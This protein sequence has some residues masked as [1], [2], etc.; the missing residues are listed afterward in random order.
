V[1]RPVPAYDI[2]SAPDGN[3][4]ERFTVLAPGIDVDVMPTSFGQARLWF[5]DRLSPDSV[6]YVS[7]FPLRVRGPF[8]EAAFEH[9][10]GVVV[11]RHEALRTRFAAVEGEPVQVIVPE[12]RIPV[13]RMDLSGNDDPLTSAR[14][15]ARQVA[16]TRF[17]LARGPLVRVVAAR[18]GADDWALLL[19]LHHIVVD[20]WS[21]GLLLAELAEAYSARLASRP[22]R[23]PPLTLQYGDY[24]VW[25]R[26]HFRGARLAE[27]LGYWRDQLR[28]PPPLMLPSDRLRPSRQ[29][30]RG[31]REAITVEASAVTALRALAQTE[32]ASLFMCLLAAY[33]VL[34]Q[35][36]SGQADLLIGTPVAGRTRANLEPLIGFFV[37]MLVLRLD[38]SGQP[39]FRELLRRTRSVALDA[40]SQQD[41]PFER[42]V[43]ELTPERR[44]SHN[45]LF[46]TTFAL[47][48][49]AKADLWPGLQV[50]QLAVPHDSVK[51]DLA[52]TCA[53]AGYQLAARFTY[54]TDLFDASTIRRLAAHYGTVLR[55]V[56]RQPDRP[57][58]QLRLLTAAERAVMDGCNDTGSPVP[59]GCVHE[60][61]ATN[62]RRTPDAPAIECEGS[63]VSYLDLDRRSERLAQML[64]ALG[65]EPDRPVALL[66]A[67]GVD[68]VSAQLGVLKA[69]AAFLPLDVTTPRR[70]IAALLAAAK[71]LAVLTTSEHAN[72][73]PHDAPA[74][75]LLDHG[76]PP[77]SGPARPARA[78]TPD[79]LAYLIATSGTTGAPKLV[80]IE[81]RSVV[82]YLT[83]FNTTVLGDGGIRML[84]LSSPAFDA[85]VKQLIGPL[86]RG[87]PVWLPS[88]QERLDP[89]RLLA[90]L[91]ARPQVAL[92]CVPAMWE[93]LLDHLDATGARP[94]DSLELVL[95]GGERLT[96]QLATRTFATF[97][98]ATLWN[99]YGPTEATVNVLGGV[100]QPGEVVTIGRPIANATA[101]V[102]GPGGT[103]QPI[104]V[105]GELYVGGLGLARGYRDDPTQTKA[106]FGPHPHSPGRRLYRTGDRVVRVPDGR[107][108]FIGRDDAQVKVR[109]VRI[110]LDEIA[111]SLREHPAVRDAVVVPHADG[112]AAYLV[113]NGEPAPAHELR[114]HL[115]A[116]LPRAALPATFTLLDRLPLTAVGKL[117]R[118]ALPAPRTRMTAS[119]IPEART[120]T[121]ERVAAIWRAL[122]EQDDFGRDDNFFDVGGHSLLLIRVHSRL[123]PATPALSVLDLFQYPT[124]RTLA[125]RIDVL[126][127]GS[128]QRAEDQP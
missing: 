72:L 87:G 61:F 114:E 22:P 43:S 126:R 20:A 5:L 78:V 42:L 56:G 40:Y 50:S 95:L 77:G 31:G 97:P 76:L 25:Q 44:L 28:H 71:P 113:G 14:T 21:A 75:L 127:A 122:L 67:H 83:W 15:L 58:G 116:W 35:R 120:A 69:G 121:E 117:D 86:L 48:T 54:A 79:N 55:E 30:H 23:L 96:D 37:N 73:L 98:S 81:H 18:L 24:A 64:T 60:L 80:E 90:A 66:L 102:L 109:G 41:I 33:G 27:Q 59:D 19:A 100:V 68:L 38:L 7:D 88:P 49:G 105:P 12:L 119:A 4:P 104:G 115:V 128:A 74:V 103:S 16:A 8:D 34:L 39:T 63:V 3:T 70:R 46:Q 125:A 1:N 118:P 123:L 53:E 29:S 91:A 13:E 26:R 62:V 32:N 93:A 52:L 84:A 110:E 17:D 57:V 9:A 10:L 101:H 92:S 112:L 82:N 6:A 124:L 99:L 107:I 36:W 94:P 47:Q 45:P 51:F 2:A 11:D 108:R 89:A 106:M 85:S 65:A 111:A